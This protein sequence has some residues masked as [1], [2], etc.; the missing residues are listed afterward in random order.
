MNG[1]L[2]VENRVA[3]WFGLGIEEF[4][5]LQTSEVHRTNYQAYILQKISRMFLNLWLDHDVSFISC[6]QVLGTTVQATGFPETKNFV[7]YLKYDTSKLAGVTE[8]WIRFFGRCP[9][10]DA[11]YPSF[12]FEIGCLVMVVQI[13]WEIQLEVS[14][15]L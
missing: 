15:L 5:P 6:I 14:A 3:S 8:A 4:I 12:G 1:Y 9:S 2:V 11:R 10:F 7:T 13:S